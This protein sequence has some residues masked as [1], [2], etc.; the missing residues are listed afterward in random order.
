MVDWRRQAVDLREPRELADSPGR[1]VR[2]AVVADLAGAD[3]LVHRLDLLEDRGGRLLLRG[4]VAHRPE[5]RD[6]PLRPVDLVEV[7]VVGAQALER[8]VDRPADVLLRERGLA[9]A[10]PL[11]VAPGAGDLGRDHDLVARLAR[12]PGA[13]DRLGP[14]V[15]LRAGRDRVHLRGVDE[16]DAV[17]ERAIELRV[18]LA[19]VGLLAEGHR[20]EAD[21]GDRERG[22]GKEVR[23][24]PLISSADLI[25]NA[26]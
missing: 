1:F 16:V 7:D 13:D 8:V 24:H 5:H 18:R 2:H 4:V 3:E 23:F 22:A 10:H 21:L 15:G 19:L 6:V 20:A 12:E 11:A 26:G 17:S 14:R 25:R 9:A